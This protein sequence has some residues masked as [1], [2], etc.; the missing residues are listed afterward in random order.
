MGLLV[1]DAEDY[2]EVYEVFAEASVR[3]L[4]TENAALRAK[5]TRL[6][7]AL[8]RTQDNL[9]SAVGGRPVR[10]MAENLAENRAALADPEGTP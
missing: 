3:G 8:E 9:R 6:T 2:H 10:D 4:L 1:S 7:S 5:V